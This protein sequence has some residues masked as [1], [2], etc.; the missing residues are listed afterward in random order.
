MIRYDEVFS[1]KEHI[2]LITGSTRGIGRGL[3]DSIA[4]A[5]ADVAVV[6]TREETAKAVAEEIREQFGVRTAGIG[7]DVRD[8]SQVRAMFDRCEELLGTPDRLLND[9]GITLLKPALEVE[10]E[11]F[12]NVID[13]NLN[14]AFY[15]CREFAKRLIRQGKKG[16]I[17]NL[18]SNSHLIVTR[19]QKEAAYNA[20]KAGLLMLTKTLAIEWMEYGI[21]VNSVSPGYIFTDMVNKEDPEWIRQWVESIP[22]GRMGTPDELAGAFL[23]LFSDSSGFTTGCDMVIDGG[24]TCV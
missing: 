14:G 3:A 6:G 17:V 4:A 20:S 24:Y 10:D 5:G 13:V 1:L 8:S 21:R 11:E 16:A 2:V 12:K 15:C 18:V 22:L 9:A 19:P 7:C 23:Y